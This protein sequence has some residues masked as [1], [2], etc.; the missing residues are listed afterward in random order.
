[1]P[2]VST[3]VDPGKVCKQ[4]VPAGSKAKEGTKV[5]FATALAPDTVAVPDE[6]GK[7]QADAQTDLQNAGLGSDI[8]TAYSDTVD[9]GLVISQ[10]V[11]PNTK[12][13]KGTVVTL[14]VS[15]GAQPAQQV[16][17]PNIYTYTRDD[18]INALMSAGLNGRCTGDEDGTVV[19]MDPDAGTQVDVGSTVTF[20]LQHAST[21]VEVPD[22]SGM[23]GT[24]ALAAIQAVGLDLDYD[25]DNPD[26][27]I[28][29]TSPDAGTQVDLGSVIEAV[30][31]PEPTPEPVV[32]DWEPNTAAA[33]STLSSDEQQ[34]FDAAMANDGTYS[35]VA[36]LATQVV[37]GQN[38]A[39]L[40]QGGG[41]W[42]IVVANSDTD[43]NVSLVSTTALAAGSVA[44][45]ASGDGDGAWQAN[46]ACASS[47]PSDAQ[48]AF[49]DAMS[50]YSGASVQPVALIGTQVVSGTNYQDICVGDAIYAAIINQ[51]ASGASQ[52]SSMDALD[53][54]T[55]AG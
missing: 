26:K 8:S 33:A 6:T 31:D 3:D 16:E 29:S 47:L 35:P 21:L 27:V 39:F 4:S 36:T 11:A 25:T 41:G 2:V 32:G 9:E 53:W 52:V 43:G 50:N 37:D 17:V 12:V 24:D 19:A 42:A 14:Q 15:L 30:Y 34:V 48:A 54:G 28:S 38:Y 13:A 44:T 5:T 22:V 40:C 7:A 55:Y 1:N 46:P 23:S 51:D 18:A 45:A 10:S 20:T 49:D